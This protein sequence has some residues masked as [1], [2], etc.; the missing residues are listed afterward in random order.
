MLNFVSID[1]FFK[2]IKFNLIKGHDL[3]SQ[4]AVLSSRLEKL[5]IA[6]WSRLGRLKRSITLRQAVHM[7]SSQWELTAGRSV[8]DSRYFVITL[9]SKMMKQS[10]QHLYHY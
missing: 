10:P 5:G 9:K 7:K 1:L 4:F 8:L 3:A 2:R 6:H